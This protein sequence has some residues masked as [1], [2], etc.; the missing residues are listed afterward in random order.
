MLSLINT[1]THTNWL[2]TSYEKW[3]DFSNILNTLTVYCILYIV[4]CFECVCIFHFVVAA[5]RKSVPKREWTTKFGFVFQSHNE[6]GNHSISF[7]HSLHM[8]LCICGR[9][10]VR[11]RARNRLI[12]HIICQFHQSNWQKPNI[13]CR[14][15]AATKSCVHQDSFSLS[16]THSRTT[17]L[18]RTNY[19]L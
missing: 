18:K 2:R 17:W 15:A 1:R 11:E 19:L 6:T 7:R 3:T 16:H 8:F 14:L 13:A 12:Q 5:L 9:V 4:L 10:C